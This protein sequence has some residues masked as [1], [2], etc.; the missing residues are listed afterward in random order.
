MHSL[1]IQPMSQPRYI[2]GRGFV[3]DIVR[4]FKHKGARQLMGMA[5]KQVGKDMLAKAAEVAPKLLVP[6]AAATVG[7]LASTAL[8][9]ARATAPKQQPAAQRSGHQVVPNPIA[10]APTA[11][12]LTL[13]VAKNIAE[14]KAENPFAN[15]FATEGAQRSGQGLSKR[16][17]KALKKLV[18]GSGLMKY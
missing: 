10:Q 12:D 1:R 3:G 14:P 17:Q 9:R 13:S 5:A 8:G 18:S 15:D 16:N 11:Q 4:L 7:A 2:A 6:A